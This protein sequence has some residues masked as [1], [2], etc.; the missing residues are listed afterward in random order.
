M[1]K[2]HML[3]QAGMVAALAIIGSTT[4]QAADMVAANTTLSGINALVAQANAN[5]ATAAIGGDTDAISEMIARAYA[6]DVAYAKAKAATQ[7]LAVAADEASEAA[8][9]AALNAAYQDANAAM[10]GPAP[11]APAAEDYQQWLESKM[12][13]AGA[14]DAN[15]APNIQD[16]I[17]E[18]QGLRQFY[19]SMFGDFWSTTGGD[20]RFGDRDATPE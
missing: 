14:V 20:L 8:A 9:Q 13:S 10:T 4:V 18:T 12:N 19:Q 3:K 5:V 2:Q 7:Q 17:W 16:P 15:D 6:V 1:K 11:E